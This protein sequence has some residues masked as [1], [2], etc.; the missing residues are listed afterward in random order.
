MITE[1]VLIL[2]A[3]CYYLFCVFLF[4]TYIQDTNKKYGY[5]QIAKMC[6]ITIIIAP[7]ALPILFG[8][9]IGQALK[10]EF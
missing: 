3:L 9:A 2:F 4:A 7:I 5:W 6:T 10:D 1:I 8:I